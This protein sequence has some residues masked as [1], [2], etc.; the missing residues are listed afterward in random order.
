MMEK[1]DSTTSKIVKS[2]S[3]RQSI[4]FWLAILILVFVVLYF[5][6]RNRPLFET[7]IGKINQNVDI[8]MIIIACIGL[9]LSSFSYKGQKEKDKR[10]TLSSNYNKT[11]KLFENLKNDFS[12]FIYNQV[13]GEKGIERFITSLNQNSINK[14]IIS[15]DFKSL[16]SLFKNYLSLVERIRDVDMDGND[17]KDL[18]STIYIFYSANLD[19]HCNKL[20]RLLTTLN[21]HHEKVTYYQNIIDLNEKMNKDLLEQ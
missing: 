7:V 6:L 8:I 16:D 3:N 11:N 13:K 20:I 4:I 17:K 14:K 12:G 19:H 15:S 1:P 5:L 2:N 9:L 10:E 21:L 18:F